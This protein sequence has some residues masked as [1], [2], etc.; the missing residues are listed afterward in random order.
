MR[1]VPAPLTEDEKA[2]LARDA[3]LEEACTKA[4]DRADETL[5]EWGEILIAEEIIADFKTRSIRTSLSQIR[6]RLALIRRE[7]EQS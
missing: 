6:G 7:R 5:T 4:L 3:A 1:I 2:E